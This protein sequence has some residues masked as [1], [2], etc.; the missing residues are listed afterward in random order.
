MAL[1]RVRDADGNEYSIGRDHAE[2]VGLTILEGK[3]AVYGNGA[4]LPAKRQV[5]L[6]GLGKSELRDLAAERGVE[7]DDKATAADLKAAIEAEST[8]KTPAGEK[9]QE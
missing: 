3:E 7:V 2:A 1:V 4:A 9:N 5:D 8:T 6:R